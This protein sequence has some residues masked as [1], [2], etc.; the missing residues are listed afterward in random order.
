MSAGIRNDM[1]SPQVRGIT[2]SLSETLKTEWFGDCHEIKDVKADDEISSKKDRG[3][4]R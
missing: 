2:V 3:Y 1:I 4:D